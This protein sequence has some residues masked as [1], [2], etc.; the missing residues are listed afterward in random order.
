M[1]KVSKQTKGKKEKK[2]TRQKRKV[3]AETEDHCFR[4]YEGGELVM[5]D[6]KDCRKVYHLDCLSLATAP[7][8]IK[9]SHIDIQI[10][11][12]IKIF[13][14]GHWICPWH[15]C[16]ECGRKAIQFCTVCSNS[17]CPTHAANAGW[18][19]QENLGLIC[20]EHTPEDIE[21]HVKRRAGLDEETEGSVTST[22]V[23]SPEPSTS[24]LSSEID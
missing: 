12:K 7:K 24:S 4:C 5:C 17:V 1:D 22:D 19:Q 21:Y 11:F 2:K 9:Y 8:G 6:M 20:K 23:A 16:D 10:E 13:F 18:V 14:I 3:K 15:H